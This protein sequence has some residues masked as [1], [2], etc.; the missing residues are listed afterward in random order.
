MLI[1]NPAR[2]FK[3]LRDWRWP[4]PLAI[5]SD[6]FAPAFAG[7]RRRNMIA[8]TSRSG[9][10]YL[11]DA[12]R[13]WGLDF[14][15]WFNPY[16]RFGKQS[17]ITDV[18]GYLEYLATH[19]A[20]DGVLSAKM[21]PAALGYLALGG[22][23]DHGLDGWNIAFLRRRDIVRQAISRE[24]A[25]RTGLW[26]AKM[27]ATGAVQES[28]Y[29]FDEL[30]RELKSILN[31]NNQW[32]TLLNGLGL[33]WREVWHEDV[34]AGGDAY[35]ADLAAFFGAPARVPEAQVIPPHTPLVQRPTNQS[36]DLNRIW[37]E[38]FHQD[39]RRRVS[40]EAAEA[41]AAGAG[42]AAG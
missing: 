21:A 25:R 29:D 18:T 31:E 10:T 1:A 35:L 22:Q 33:P 23:M 4:A 38:R 28:D 27:A 34:L 42:A 41:I 14:A 40:A 3:G 8:C 13:P 20:R 24:V 11:C 39:F 36:T 7:L 9:S 16:W 37:A 30:H 17:D 15:E 6:P 5:H 32:L 2:A 19:A 26:T 12:L